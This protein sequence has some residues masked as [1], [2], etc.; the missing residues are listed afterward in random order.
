MVNCFVILNK[1]QNLQQL[2][3]MSYNFKLK[4]KC[5]VCRLHFD[6][7]DNLLKHKEASS[8]C[9][10]GADFFDS[11]TSSKSRHLEVVDDEACYYSDESSIEFALN[12]T[13]NGNNGEE[14]ISDGDEEEEDED[15]DNFNHK[16]YRLS[17]I[18]NQIKEKNSK[19]NDK[20]NR[21]RVEKIVELVDLSNEVRDEADPS[22]NQIKKR[23]KYNKYRPSGSTLTCESIY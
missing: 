17:T 9:T 14:N 19:K 4:L 6:R 18:N 10:N 15:E 3:S 21:N 2:D 7:L 12:E 13:E 20:T 1:T 5:T 23:R 8:G 16:H 22:S 11:S